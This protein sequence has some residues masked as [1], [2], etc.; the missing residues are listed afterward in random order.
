MDEIIIIKI[1][2]GILLSLGSCILFFLA[3]LLYFKYLVQ[4]KNAHQEPKV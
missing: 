2:F 1:I 4:E 3:Y